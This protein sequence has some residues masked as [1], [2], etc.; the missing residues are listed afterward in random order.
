MHFVH[1]HAIGFETTDLGAKLIAGRFEFSVAR[2]DVVRGDVD[3]LQHEI[4]RCRIIADRRA[5]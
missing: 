5:R 3:A 4:G 1:Y 2:E